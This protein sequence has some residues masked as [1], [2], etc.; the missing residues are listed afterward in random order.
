MGLA[1]LFASDAHSS[2]ARTPHMDNLLR[3]A[4]ECCDP[5]CAEILLETNPWRVLEGLPMVVPE[6]D[7]SDDE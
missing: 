4:E 7:W 2:Y 6:F 1:H 5:E 3:W